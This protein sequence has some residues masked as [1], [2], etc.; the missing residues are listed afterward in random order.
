MRK[1]LPL[2]LLTAA[3]FAVYAPALRNDFVWDDQA[4]VLRDPL[5]RSWR[6]VPESFQHFLFIDATASDFYRP[7]Q[8]LSY[9]LDY[10]LYAFRPAGY[11]LTS[12]TCHAAAALAFYFFA[13]ELLGYFGAPE[14]ARRFVPFFATLAWAVH[15]LQSSAVAYISG[16]ADPLAAAFGFVGLWFGLRSLRATGVRRWCDTLAAGAALLL[17]CLSKESGLVF[18]VLWLILLALQKHWRPL[19]HAGVVTLFVAV[20]YFSL[21]L[22][23]EHFPAPVLGQ[24]APLQV[25][26]ILMARAFAAYSGLIVY[27]MHLHMERTVETRPSGFGEASLTAAAWRELQT[28]AGVILVAGFAY[29]VFR[30]RTRNRAVFACLVLALISYL[31]VSG[32]VPLNATIAEHWLY[33]P[34]AFLFLAFG[35]SAAG[36]LET[37]RP[38]LRATFTAVAAVWLLFCAGRTFVRTFDWRDQRTFLER[39]L[40]SGADP[41]RM[42]IN[43]G[44]LELGEGNLSAAKKHLDAALAKE[45][46]QP[47]AVLNR[48]SVAVK[49]NDF[50]RAHELLQRATEMPLVDAQA[51]ELLAVLENKEFGRANPL[52]LRLAA[53]TGQ[54][55]WAIEK[56]YVRFLAEIGA[57][58][59]AI[60]ELRHCLATQWYRADSWLLL[61][62]LEAKAGNRVEA[63]EALAQ[64]RRYDVHLRNELPKL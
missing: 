18:P 3:I 64:A 17:S 45:P 27:P 39:T 41:V 33:L 28:L 43:L 55:N 57:V 32:I 52:R 54:P 5:I 20:T 19:L 12:V 31:P 37:V 9:T 59:S 58:D 42:L 25:R 56:R 38:R 21:R 61:A 48:A 10:A 47:L 40:A 16:R 36:G 8:R 63:Q 53:R 11:H 49:E 13:L 51:Y 24:P 30:A 4:L 14:R 1:F 23:A 29:W 6:L 2:L 15:P 35:L 7:I 46:D 22:P 62:A 34:S 26:P 60:A 44:G 50:P